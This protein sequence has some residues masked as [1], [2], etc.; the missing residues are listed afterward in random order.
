[1]TLLPRLRTAAEQRA[2]LAPG[3]TIDAGVAFVLVRE[4]L[5]VRA[6]DRRPE[7]TIE[8]WRGTCS[9][10][11]Y[12][13]RALLKEL[14]V[15]S[16]LMAATHDFTAQNSPWLPP[17][18]L[19]EVT[20]APVPDV[21]NFLQVLGEAA[22]EEAWY[23]VDA[24]WPLAARSLGLPAN[25]ALVPGRHMRLAADIEELFHVP[26]GDDPQQF[27]Q[28]LLERHAAGQIERRER[29]IEALSAWLAEQLG[30]GA[31]STVDGA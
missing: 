19:A 14:G 24:T 4:M 25:E 8:E 18:L 26:D 23:A 5:Y 16:M 1:M 7:T 31:P 2:M 27:K 21:H 17:P 30:A 22:G 15:P 12:L 28:R 3:A 11:H 9:G 29:F 10:K 20:A 6:S 13:L